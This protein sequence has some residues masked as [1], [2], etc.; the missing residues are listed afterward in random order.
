MILVCVLTGHTAGFDDPIRY[1]FY[2]LRGPALTA[3]AIVITTCADKYFIIGLCVLL[4]ILPQTRLTFGVPL[5]AG[6]L[7][8][9]LLN[10]IIKH[11][12]QRPRPEVLH[13][14]NE[15]GFSFASGH[16]ITSMFF[17]GLA[18]WLVCRYVT[19]KTAR[20]ILVA[21]LAIPMLLVGPSRVYLGVHYPTDVLGAWCLGFAAVV[22]VIEI[23]RARD[24][25]N[26]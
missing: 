24:D 14:V 15:H 18:I 20:N 13:L 5:S 17:Y 2:G 4:L 9:M 12:V 7:G 25:A 22:V 21:L 8:T 6:A 3:V 16:S 26:R 10:T 1:F 23:I 11:I 19:N